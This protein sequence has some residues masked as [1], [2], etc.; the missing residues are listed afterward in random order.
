MFLGAG[1]IF[2]VDSMKNIRGKK[3]LINL[4]E[5]L[6]HQKESSVGLEKNKQKNA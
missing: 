6:I 2:H 1:E 5:G 3:L 4:P